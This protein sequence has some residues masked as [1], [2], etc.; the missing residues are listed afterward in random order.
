MLIIIQRGFEASQH[1]ENTKLVLSN[2]LFGSFYNGIYF[3][4]QTYTNRVNAG[5]VA[6]AKCIQQN[7][8][9]N[10]H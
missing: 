7:L 9:G 4:K 8:K 2:S 10:A 1:F 3:W 5:L 6:N